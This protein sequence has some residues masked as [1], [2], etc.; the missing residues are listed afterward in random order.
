MSILLPH[1]LVN[2]A[3]AMLREN[4]ANYLVRA[5]NTN[6]PEDVRDTCKSMMDE[7]AAFLKEFNSVTKVYY[8]A[9]EMLNQELLM[10]DE[11]A[12]PA[13]SFAVVVPVLK[14]YEPNEKGM[15]N[16]HT[17][18]LGAVMLLLVRKAS[19]GDSYFSEC[20][21]VTSLISYYKDGYFPHWEMSATSS[22]Y[23]LMAEGD[24]MPQMRVRQMP[25]T[26]QFSP[27]LSRAEAQES[28]AKF[29]ALA[30]PSFLT[31]FFQGYYRG[32]DEPAT[33]LSLIYPMAN[34][35]RLAL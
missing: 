24:E 27:W 25:H 23:S 14:S 18:N 21:E 4:S 2:T 6:L 15:M 5:N 7:I 10:I 13:D 11:Q 34:L 9:P 35:K 26:T 28:E 8:M 20:I 31:S 17:D 29:I 16:V 32:H 22:I 1:D 19:Y 33:K 3:I 12:M 30:V